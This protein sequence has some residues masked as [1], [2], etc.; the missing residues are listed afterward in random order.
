MGNY[1]LDKVDRQILE[2]LTTDA[3]TPY[4]E[5]ARKVNV[6]PGTVHVRMRKMETAGVVKKPQLQVDLGVLG[7]D[8]TAFIGVIL[9]R[10][11]DYDKVVKEV[12]KI[13]EVLFCHYITGTY[14]LFLKV[15]C[16]DTRHLRDV[17]S[18]RIQKING[19][20][21]TETL[22]SLEETF[23]RQLKWGKEVL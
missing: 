16:R 22:I 17:L 18:D 20:S 15:T 21:R 5:I 2:I 8:V 6:A 7:W 14:S 3:F 13:P 11:E 4:T 9:T 19:I 1:Q 23:N 12:Q 10:S